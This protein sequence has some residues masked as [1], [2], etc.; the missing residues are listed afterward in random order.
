MQTVILYRP[1]GPEEFELVKE[2]EFPWGRNI[3]PSGGFLHQTWK[4]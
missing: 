4:S 2:S 1:T 3:T